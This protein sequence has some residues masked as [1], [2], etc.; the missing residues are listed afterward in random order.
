LNQTSIKEDRPI[1]SINYNLIP[2]KAPGTL[3]SSIAGGDS[4]LNIRW[5]T[6]QD[7]AY[8][9][10]LNR[11]IGDITVRQA[12]IAK[13]VDAIELSLGN[14]ARYPFITQPKVGS[15]TSAIDLPS[16]WIW[17]FHASLP[18]KWENLRL[19]KIKRL[20]GE[21]GTTSG[22]DGVLRLIFTASTENTSTEVA[23]FS[24]DYDI[25]S[26]L[27]YQLVRLSV[28]DSTEESMP[29]SASESETVAGFLTFRTLDTS[30]LDVTTFLD[31][32]AP[33]ANPTD[34]DNDGVYDVPSVYEIVDSTPGSSTIVDDF[35]V[36]AISHGTGLMTDSA[37]NTIPPLDSDVLSWVQAFNYPFD[38]DAN[39]TSVN[40]I[41]IPNGL[42]AEFDILAPTGDQPTGDTSGLYYP[43]W[44]NR[45][46]KVD[47]TGSQLR[48]Y[49]ATYNVTDV[50]SGGSPNTEPVEF[51]TLDLL[52][53]YT[54]NEIVDIVPINNLQLET[55]ADAAD[56]NQQF[57]RGH[58]KL[59]SLW[60]RTTSFVDD[61]FDA[62]DVIVDDPADTEYSQGSTRLSSFSVSRS[63]KYIPTIGQSRA[64]RGSTSRR[65]I[66]LSPSVD[67][68]Y[69]TELDQG[70]G[71]QIDLEAQDGINP[72]AAIDRF[73]NSGSLVHKMVRL[74]IDAD[75]LGDDPDFYDNEVLPRLTI[76]LGRAPQF[77]DYWY[78][79]TRFMIFNGSTWQ[80]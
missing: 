60:D 35:S 33:P 58:V 37:F 31:L 22:Y 46:E 70:L 73:G 63:S 13:A 20:S 23:I 41:V 6:S 65:T 61:F 34:N 11:P 56:F 62:F 44:I 2:T 48:M 77:G 14:Q 30:M 57:G 16:Q 52:S 12:V 64:L 28:V 47:S 79:G 10:V 18:K 40:G 66:P 19:A 29:I 53:S 45:I 21:N 24:A 25:G 50:E 26:F 5:L 8:F 55:G 15:G 17:D 9:A 51:G 43:V 3:F 72:I 68:M 42:F 49:F 4:T 54:A 7:P 67:N 39:R 71:N 76:L 80:G 1:P 59:S 32:V 74:V 36:T 69:V 78:N 38:S 27:S 75:S